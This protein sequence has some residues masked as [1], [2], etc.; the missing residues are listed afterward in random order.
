[1]AETPGASGGTGVRRRTQRTK[2]ALSDA[3]YEALLTNAKT[4]EKPARTAEDRSRE[5]AIVDALLARGA[6]VQQ[7]VKFCLDGGLVVSRR[8]VSERRA[9]LKGNENPGGGGPGGRGGFEE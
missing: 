2:K 9:A 6:S 5:A 7:A 4:F 1:M 3:Q 8:F